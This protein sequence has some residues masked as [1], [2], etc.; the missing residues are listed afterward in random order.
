MEAAG[1][2]SS[3]LLFSSWSYL[4]GSSDSTVSGSR[5]AV[6]CH[7]CSPDGNLFVVAA[8]VDQHA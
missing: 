7:S 8:A 3:G 5:V 1:L 2:W 4:R 6:P